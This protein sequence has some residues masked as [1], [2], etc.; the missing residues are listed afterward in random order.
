MGF[1]ARKW[2]SCPP[3]RTIDLLKRLTL[4]GLLRAGGLDYSEQSEPPCGAALPSAVRAEGIG[5]Q[6][7]LLTITNHSRSKITP[8]GRAGYVTFRASRRIFRKY[9]TMLGCT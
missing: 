4:R 6:V 3:T 2:R 9:G 8:S 7:F 1:N 5:A